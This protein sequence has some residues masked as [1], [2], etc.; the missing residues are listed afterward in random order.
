[1]AVVVLARLWHVGRV[2]LCVCL[3]QLHSRRYGQQG[4]GRL[5]PQLLLVLGVVLVASQHS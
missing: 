2:L 1:M 4:N 3:V 5:G